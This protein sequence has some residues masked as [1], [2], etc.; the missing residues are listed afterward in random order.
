MAATTKVLERAGEAVI[1]LL[2][3]SPRIA[4]RRSVRNRVEHHRL[5]AADLTVI[6]HPKSGSTW[7]RFQLAR[8]YQRKFGLP[9]SVIPRI[10]RYHRLNPAIP[11]LHMAGYQYIAR[12]V[13]R[14]APDAELAGKSAVFLLRHPLDVIVSLYFHIQKHALHE[15]KLFN[16]WPLDLAEVPM[17][18]FAMHSHWGLRET[19]EFYNGCARHAAAMPRA[20][21]LRYEDMRRDPARELSAILRFAGADSTP[22]DAA[23]A[24]AFTSFERLQAAE[25]DNVF[26][27]ARLRPGDPNDLESFKVR[28]AKVFGYRDYF[29]P[30][31]CGELEAI[32]DRELD[33]TLGYSIR[34]VGRKLDEGAA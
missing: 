27:S 10:E 25:R 30:D 7:L 20:H 9:E 34:E 11:R 31:Q 17:I 3:D 5:R 23:D 15:R 1:G 8:V 14:P 18:D 12:V 29:S 6:A 32:I 24:A 22:E 28:R 13:A 4:L 21:I 26:E 2:P 33:P 19:I 16:D